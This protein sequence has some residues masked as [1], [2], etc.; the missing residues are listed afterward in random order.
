MPVRGDHLCDAVLRS[1]ERRLGGFLGDG[2]GPGGVR[3]QD[4]RDGVDRRLRT[5]RVAKSPAGHRVGLGER[6]DADDAA[7]AE[8]AGRRHVLAFEHDLV[9]A[10]V[11]YEPEVV[12]HGKVGERLHDISREDGTGR[13]GWTV[14]QQD[15]RAGSHQRLQPLHVGQEAGGRLERVENGASSKPGRHHPVVGP[16]R[17]RQQHLVAWRQRGRKGRRERAY[18]AHCAGDLRR[19]HRVAVDALDLGRD[20]LP[21]REQAL[22]VRIEGPAL[23]DGSLG[24][25]ADVVRSAEVGLADVQADGAWGCDGDV[26]DLPNPGVEHLR[27]ARGERGE[28]HPAMVGEPQWREGEGA[29]LARPRADGSSRSG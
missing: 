29:G 8:E 19:A 27:R 17:V 14:D 7:V 26:R 25:L 6:V 20:P 21:E 10:L 1:V 2:V 11:A 13:V 22:G 9:V 4:L 23:V 18:P 24:G 16:A 12:T 5:D 3:L 28:G 15:A